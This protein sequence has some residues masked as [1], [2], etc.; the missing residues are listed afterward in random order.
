MTT[1]TLVTFLLVVGIIELFCCTIGVANGTA[2]SDGR[3]LMWKNRDISG[4]QVVK[5]YD[6]CRNR[7]VGV[8]SVGTDYV[9]MGV[10]DKGFAI[11]NALSSDLE[12]LMGN[13]DLMMFCLPICET[14]EDFEVILDST[15]VEGRDTHTNYAVFDSTGAAAIYEVGPNQ[16]WKFDTSDATGGFVVRTTFSVNGGGSYGIEKYTRSQALIEELLAESNINYRS[17]IQTHTRDYSDSDSNPYEIPFSDYDEPGI[18][19]GYIDTP[20]SVCEHGNGSAAIFRGVLPGEPANLSVMW[21]MLGQPASAIATPVFPLGRPPLELNTDDSSLL[22]TRANEI[23]AHVYNCPFGST[24]ADT[25]KL[26]N[27]A[28]TGI[29]DQVFPMEIQL[30]DAFDDYFDAWTSAMPDDQTILDAQQSMATT[31]CDF[32]LDVVVDSMLTAYFEADNVEPHPTDIVLFTE[33]SL[34]G[35]EE[36]RWDFDNDGYYDSSDQNPSH[37]YD[38]VGTYS[39]KLTVFNDNEYA[40][41]VRENYINVV[42]RPPDIISHVPQEMEFQVVLDQSIDFSVDYVDDDGDPT[43]IQWYLDDE[44]FTQLPTIRVVFNQL[45]DHTVGFAV[46]DDYSETRIDWLIHV[47]PVSEDDPTVPRYTWSLA[48]HPNPFNPSTTVSFSLK[49]DSDVRVEVYDVRGRKVRTLANDRY[50]AGLHHIIWNGQ[51]DDGKELSSGV[52]LLKLTTGERSLMRKA[53]MVK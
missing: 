36:W 46:R 52:Y 5:Y 44:E 25:Y 37:T 10:N 38:E 18:S 17:I 50:D 22:C 9:W 27:D 53:L 12:R 47:V 20:F 32:L 33:R 28:G 2:T 29:W 13:G 30:F 23:K 51:N 16:Y 11:G 48:N 19:W 31:A 26:R 14:L 6:E 43:S 1:K 7:F 15:N 45:R 3:P 21:T 34:H 8:G 40:T 41:T 39:V 49:R 4:S 24:Y 42:N 35:P